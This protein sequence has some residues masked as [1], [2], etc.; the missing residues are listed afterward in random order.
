V[1]KFGFGPYLGDAR[2]GRIEKTVIAALRQD[3]T[4]KR[5]L[6]VCGP[7]QAAK[8]I[9]M[10]GGEE[11]YEVPMIDERRLEYSHRFQ[12]PGGVP[13]DVKAL[14]DVLQNVLSLR[15]LANLDFAVVLDWYKI[16]DPEVAPNDWRNTEAGDL[17]SRMKYWNRTPSKQEAA[18]DELADRFASTVRKHP[19]LRDAET[20]LTVPGSSANYD[21]HGERLARLVAERTGK[22]LVWTTPVAGPR[23]QRKDQAS[24]IK[25]AG[26]FSLPSSVSGDVIVID[27]VISAGETVSAVALAAH[28]GGAKRVAALAGVKTMRN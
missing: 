13:D 14:C 28:L 1:V 25:L 18:R 3:Q 9:S 12:C 8:Q 21:S 5:W 22:E 24:H 10:V 11:C 4:N 15:K 16:P 19:F 6:Y 7:D 27:D 17:V 20:T 26:A 23:A 2:A